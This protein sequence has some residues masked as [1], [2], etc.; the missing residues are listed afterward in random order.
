MFSLIRKEK[1]LTFSRKMAKF[2][3]VSH[4]SHHPIETLWEHSVKWFKRLVGLVY[5]PTGMQIR[6]TP[7]V[8]YSKFPLFLFVVV[9]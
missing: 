4:Q 8:L 6:N 9:F 7:R 5:G 2:F 1:M 3:A